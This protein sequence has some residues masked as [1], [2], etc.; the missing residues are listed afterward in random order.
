M[1]ERAIAIREDLDSAPAK[2]RG[3]LHARDCVKPSAGVAWEPNAIASSSS[4]S[5]DIDV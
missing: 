2:R 5:Y 3:D 1:S 4:A